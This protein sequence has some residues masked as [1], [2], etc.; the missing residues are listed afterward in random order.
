MIEEDN[1]GV[2]LI[3]KQPSC[4]DSDRF[5]PWTNLLTNPILSP[6]RQAS[7]ANIK[8]INVFVGRSRII[9]LSAGL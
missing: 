9:M 5:G 4:V 6:A 3:Q 1:V 8:L 7:R 2:D